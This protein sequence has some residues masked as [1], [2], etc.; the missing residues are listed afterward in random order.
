[1]P[2]PSASTEDD[3]TVDLAAMLLLGGTTTAAKGAHVKM[4]E[5]SLAHH[6]PTGFPWA[7]SGRKPSRLERNKEDQGV[8]SAVIL[9]GGVSTTAA[10][11]ALETARPRRPR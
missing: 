5:P 6:T 9:L 7:V 11:A 3:Q 1:M 2:S 10:K 4:I 8:A